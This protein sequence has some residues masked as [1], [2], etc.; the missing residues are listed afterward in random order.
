MRYLI[1][2]CTGLA[3]VLSV[4]W[5]SHTHK[6]SLILKRDP[7][8]WTADVSGTGLTD[9]RYLDQPLTIPWAS[10]Q[11]RKIAGCAC[12]GNAGNVSP[13]PTSKETASLRSRHASRHVRHARA[14]MHTGIA[15]PRRRGKRSRYSWR[16]RNIIYANLAI[17][18]YH[19]SSKPG[20]NWRVMETVHKEKMC[21]FEFPVILKLLHY[22]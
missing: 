21:A 3:T 9:H 12:A 8:G 11:I 19:T 13:P 20:M 14:V 16:M 18:S 2:Q 22:I 7:D 17:A 5:E 10:C 15:N 4:C 6:D 1:D